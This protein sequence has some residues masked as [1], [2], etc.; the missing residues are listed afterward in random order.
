LI[1]LLF[2]FFL[3]LSY[4][5]SSIDANNKD[6]SIGSRELYSG[7]NI[8]NKKSKINQE[9]ISYEVGPKIDSNQNLVSNEHLVENATK[10]RIVSVNFG[11][12]LLRTTGFLRLVKVLEENNLKPNIFVTS[13]LS[14]L[15]IALY[16]HYGSA[17]LAEWHW[18]K[19]LQSLDKKDEFLT[20]KMAKKI[21]G[22][23]HLTFGKKYLEELN[24]PIFVNFYNNKT[25]ESVLISKGELSEILMASIFPWKNVDGENTHGQLK[26]VFN[27]NTDRYFKSDIH[28]NFNA[29]PTLVKFNN[30][31]TGFSTGAF[32][33]FS[34]VVES[35]KKS[36]NIYS[37]DEKFLELDNLDQL[38]SLLTYF[39]E[40][41]REYVQKHAREF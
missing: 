29:V 24:A 13:G 30:D 22:F 8:Q 19:F 7:V 23:I 21:E 28:I 36:T 32:K 11:P 1:N 3:S 26:A 37:F 25:N 6:K 31:K 14:S 5:C 34:N 39:E 38:P 20:S 10:N 18:F 33:V 12:G 16:V 17:Q 35:E 15:I 4:S 41:S 40:R 9:F 2:I 27:I